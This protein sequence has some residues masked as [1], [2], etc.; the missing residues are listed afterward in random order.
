MKTNIK[1]EEDLEFFDLNVTGMR[2]LFVSLKNNGINTIDD[3]ITCPDDKL[4]CHK[5]G[6]VPS[7]TKFRFYISLREV[8]RHKY[9]G[10]DLFFDSLLEKQYKNN[11]EGIEEFTNDLKK[12]GFGSSTLYSYAYGEFILRDSSTTN[13]KI[14]GKFNEVIKSFLNN[15]IGMNLLPKGIEPTDIS[16]FSMEW[17]LENCKCFG[18]GVNANPDSIP[19][20]RDYFVKYIREKKL[21]KAPV[22]EDFSD[23]SS[24]LESAKKQ[25]E[26]LV[27]QRD[28]LNGQI[29]EAEKEINRLSIRGSYGTK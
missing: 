24:R 6:D 16:T 19:N 4:P 5:A 23:Y 28:D 12:L 27:K 26:L 9:L 25:L 3:L 11:D 1:L 18:T 17:M 29:E 7:N 22:N 13:H 15:Q 21:K 2:R 20:L 10:K 14:D 8:L